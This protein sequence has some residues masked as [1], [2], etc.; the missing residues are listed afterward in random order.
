MGRE[1]YGTIREWRGGAADFS[2]CRAIAWEGIR[3]VKRFL[4]LEQFSN[5]CALF[6]C[7]RGGFS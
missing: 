7:V 2:M 1:R 6:G 4:V 3:G 5:S